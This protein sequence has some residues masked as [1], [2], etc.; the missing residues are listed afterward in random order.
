MIGGEITQLY[1][2][3]EGT[4]EDDSGKSVPV[5]AK[6]IDV[7]RRQPNGSWKLMMGDPN[8]RERNSRSDKT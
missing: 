7:L 3:F 8:A 1:T 6:A 4:R 2:D 5:H